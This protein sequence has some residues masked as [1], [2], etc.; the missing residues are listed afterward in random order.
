MLRVDV[1]HIRC[2]C[3]AQKLVDLGTTLLW[4]AMTRSLL[5]M[6]CALESCAA[7]A[8]WHSE[9]QTLLPLPGTGHGPAL[10]GHDQRRVETRCAST[11][12]AV[13]AAA[14]I[15]AARP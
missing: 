10:D 7:A 13:A 12:S 8:A 4:M 6:Y 2:R 5:G 15:T 11:P 3:L 14:A 1:L 9:S